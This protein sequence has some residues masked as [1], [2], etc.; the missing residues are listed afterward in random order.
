M[1]SE[2]HVSPNCATYRH[3]IRCQQISEATFVACRYCLG[4]EILNHEVSLF[5]CAVCEPF[6]F[7]LTMELSELN[8]QTIEVMVLSIKEK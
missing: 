5:I 1:D 8:V 3:E 6:F 4:A 2:N 7:Q